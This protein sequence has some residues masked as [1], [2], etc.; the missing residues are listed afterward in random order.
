MPQNGASFIWD[1]S[2]TK[3]PTQDWITF[4]EA[5]SHWVDQ[6]QDSHGVLH[7]LSPE[8]ID[9]SLRLYRLELSSE[10]AERQ[11]AALCDRHS[12]IGVCNGQ[13]LR[14]ALLRRP[15]S[16]PP[17]QELQE[18]S[19]LGW[20]PQDIACLRNMSD[21][22]AK[23]NHRLRA[24]AGRLISMPS[25]LAARD[26]I[27]E[28]WVELPMQSRPDLPLARSTKLSSNKQPGLNR[29]PEA[30]ANFVAALDEF[31]DQWHLL[32]L[33]TWRLPSVRGPQWVPGLAPD[34]VRLRGDMTINTPW[35]FPVL[36]EDGLGRLLED[37]HRCQA[38]ERSVDDEEN[39]QTYAS[40]FKLYYWE[41]VF[42]E[43]YPR[44]Q[45]VKRFVTEMNSVLSEIL[46]LGSERIAKLRKTLHALQSGKL[47]SLRGR[48]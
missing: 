37:E 34:D 27:R 2:A 23:I 4:C 36:A 6:R 29:A 32:G 5:H 40:M 17:D 28:L 24:A 7:C 39:W 1:V 16:W 33:T 43:R 22:T 11:F 48:R 20:T 35:H 26:R 41:I 31:C 8:D 18:F 21:P 9:A 45:R 14:Y 12:S 30:L 46:E 13:F 38:A 15:L 10:A 42:R 3:F 47:S 44:Q 25:F 19:S